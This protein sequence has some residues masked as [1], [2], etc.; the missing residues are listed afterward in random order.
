MTTADN[1]LELIKIH[2]GIS[3]SEIAPECGVTT[4]M[5]RHH[6]NFLRDHGKIKCHHDF[7]K[8]LRTLRWFVVE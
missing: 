7:K 3:V 6:I 4:R 1:I 5:V 8:D 2:P